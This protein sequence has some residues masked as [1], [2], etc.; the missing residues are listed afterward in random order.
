MSATTAQTRKSGRAATAPLAVT[1]LVIQSIGM[2]LPPDKQQRMEVRRAI[3]DREVQGPYIPPY[4]RGPDYLIAH[5]ST[6]R[7]RGNAPKISCTVV[8]NAARFWHGWEE[9]S[10]R[11]RNVRM[12]NGKNCAD[13]GAPDFAF[14]ATGVFPMQNRFRI[15][16]VKLMHSFSG[17]RTIR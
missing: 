16:S 5:A 1:E 4:H 7:R 14:G 6:V 8:Q 10:A 15:I 11:Q 13:F 12:M 17:T 3:G 2:N 9:A